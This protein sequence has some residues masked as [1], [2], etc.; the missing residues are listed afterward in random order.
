[1]HVASR[2]GN[3]ETTHAFLSPIYALM[4]RNKLLSE[5]MFTCEAGDLLDVEL[6]KEHKRQEEGSCLHGRKAMR[7]GTNQ[8]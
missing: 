4:Q 2:H 1:M 6:D 5:N 8:K 7:P 3:G